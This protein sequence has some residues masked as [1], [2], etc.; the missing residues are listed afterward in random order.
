MGYSWIFTNKHLMVWFTTCYLGCSVKTPPGH[1][2]NLA[3]PRSLRP[4]YPPFSSAPGVIRGLPEACRRHLGPQ[5][6]LFR[7]HLESFPVRLG[8]SLWLLR[9]QREW[10]MAITPNT[11][12]TRGQDGFVVEADYKLFI[13][14]A[15]ISLKCQSFLRINLEV[16]KKV[17]LIQATTTRIDRQMRRW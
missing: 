12:K 14:V 6:Q 10:K 4:D 16:I 17:A 11:Q 8:N 2:R 5:S 13:L 1:W 15:I 3:R 9:S 7:N